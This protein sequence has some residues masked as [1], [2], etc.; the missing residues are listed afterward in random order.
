MGSRPFSSVKNLGE[1]FL[2]A[3]PGHK[4]THQG[5]TARVKGG[6]AGKK[7]QGDFSVTGLEQES[8]QLLH[9]SALF[10]AEQNVSGMAW[11]ESLG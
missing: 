10:L 8:L 7:H 3:I 2:P 5:V 1:S 9:L 6:V 11:L 4:I